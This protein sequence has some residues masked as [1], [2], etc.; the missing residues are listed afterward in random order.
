VQIAQRFE[1]VASPAFG[2]PP[3]QKAYKTLQLELFLFSKTPFLDSGNLIQVDPML[4]LVRKIT[5]QC[6]LHQLNTVR[7]GPQRLIDLRKT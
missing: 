3:I 1:T 2:V 6:T 7:P 5:L 4:L